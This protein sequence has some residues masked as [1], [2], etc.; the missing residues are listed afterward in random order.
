MHDSYSSFE[1]RF[2]G[3]GR[4]LMSTILKPAVIPL[5]ALSVSPD[6]VSVSQIIVGG[7]IVLIVADHPRVAFVLFVAAL[8]LDGLDG[9]LARHSGRCSPF[10]A[11]L[12]PFCDHV[13]EILV[14]AALTRIGALDPFWGVLYAFVYP[15]FNLILFLC[16][17]HQ[18]PLPL[19]LKSY[20]VVYP[21]LFLYLWWGINWL[22]GAVA[23]SVALMGPV[24]VQG[25]F[26]LRRAL[27]GAS[28]A[29]RRS[30]S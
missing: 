4:G 9:T 14:V 30:L 15:A 24:I 29:E 25:L 13:R 10:G 11:L 23:L 2:L 5:A 7:A 20:L 17:Y 1:R 8:L 27:D 28:L 26:R 6:V 16:N 21:A 3:A 12:D 19:A 18:T 22:D